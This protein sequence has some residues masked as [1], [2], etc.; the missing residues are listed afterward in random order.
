[1]CDAGPRQARSASETARGAASQA[2]V[3]VALEVSQAFPAPQPVPAVLSA[4]PR[5]ASRGR[6]EPSP[7]GVCRLRRGAEAPPEPVALLQLRLDLQAGTESQVRLC[8]LLGAL[9]RCHRDHRVFGAS[10]LDRFTAAIPRLDP[11]LHLGPRC[12]VPGLAAFQEADSVEQSKECLLLGEKATVDVGHVR[13]R[14]LQRG[15]RRGE[16]GP[17]RGAAAVR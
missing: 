2:D 16:T 11:L 6:R 10:L 3:G 8:V 5:R 13:G 7:A 1:M 17:G 14:A 12:L 9:Q 15:L 4:W